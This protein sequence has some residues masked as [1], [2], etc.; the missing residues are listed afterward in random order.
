MPINMAI[1][2]SLLQKKK[3]KKKKTVFD[4]IMEYNGANYILNV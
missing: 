3:K 2:P 1:I 4:T